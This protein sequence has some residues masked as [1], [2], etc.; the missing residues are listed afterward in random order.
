MFK[1]YRRSG[2]LSSIDI[3]NEFTKKDGLRIFQS[4]PKN[5]KSASYDLNYTP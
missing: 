2:Q 5:I 4:D 1:H 3:K